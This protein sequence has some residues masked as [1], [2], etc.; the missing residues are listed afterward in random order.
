[1]AWKDELEEVLFRT[2][3]FQHLQNLRR[4][5]PANGNGSRK[6]RP[7]ERLEDLTC[8]MTVE[9]LA[10]RLN[11]SEK[12]IYKWVKKGQI[13]HHYVGGMLRFD[14]RLIAAWRHE[15]TVIPRKRR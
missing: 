2:G 3:N 10:G 12:T 7:I 8:D 5:E 6:K 15:R 4:E 11:C 14:P 13:P 9:E 1:M